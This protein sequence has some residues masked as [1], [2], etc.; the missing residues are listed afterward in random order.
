M[1]TA[2]WKREFYNVIVLNKSF[3]PWVIPLAA[4]LLS[5]LINIYHVLAYYSPEFVL[6]S[7][8]KRKKTHKKL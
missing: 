2:V 8:I 3:L 4:H 6:S 5:H 1:F 7:E